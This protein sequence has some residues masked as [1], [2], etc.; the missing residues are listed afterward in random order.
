MTAPI[1]QHPTELTAR[2][3]QRCG[4]ACLGKRG[5]RLGE[6]LEASAIVQAVEGDCTLGSLT[7]SHRLEGRAGKQGG[8]QGR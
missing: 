8:N 2:E 3:I 1:G 6:R 5:N 4:L 7:G